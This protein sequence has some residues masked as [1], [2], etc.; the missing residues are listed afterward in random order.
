MMYSSWDTEWN[1][2]DFLPLWA[3]FC[4]FIPPSP[5]PP[6]PLT[7]SPLTTRKIKILKKWENDLELASFYACL[8]QITI[9][10]CILTETWSAT[11]FFLS[12]L[13]IFCIFYPSNNL[14]NQNFEKMRKGPT[15]VVIL[16]SSTKNQDHM[17][18]A[19]WDME[20]DRQIS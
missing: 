14:E 1:G 3:I 20:C 12:F 6:P 9:I 13:A 8:L 16:H 4:P 18:Y 19:S 15:F 17:M 2:L 5:P 7:R 10:W 11:D